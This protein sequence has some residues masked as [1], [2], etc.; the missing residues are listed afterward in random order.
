MSKII[1]TQRGDTLF[2]RTEGD[3]TRFTSVKLLYST[4]EGDLTHSIQD[5]VGANTVIN[6]FG[7][8]PWS[9]TLNGPGGILVLNG[10]SNQAIG[11]FSTEV[12]FLKLSEARELLDVP[13]Q[14]VSDANAAVYSGTVEFS[15]SDPVPQ[16][17]PEPEPEPGFEPEPEP[18]PGFE[19]EPEPQ[20]EPQPEPEPQP[21]ED[22]GVERDFG[23]R[24]VNSA[25]IGGNMN[26][27][28]TTVRGQHNTT[29]VNADGSGGDNGADDA[30][31]YGAR[32]GAES[33]A[34]GATSGAGSSANG[35][36]SGTGSSANG[37]GNH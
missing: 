15:N 30:V 19:P 8:A 26:V 3:D 29:N 31:G 9:V 34:N 32:S 20:P 21:V 5:Q 23:V 6:A 35:A 1:F 28:T 25:A 24:V 12:P 17:E 7:E 2:V 22:L 16:P 37:N 18:E 13:A 10:N 11:P 36:T 4:A 14:E 33:G 27:V